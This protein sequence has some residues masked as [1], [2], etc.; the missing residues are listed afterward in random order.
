MKKFAIALMLVLVGLS[1]RGTPSSASTAGRAPV[2]PAKGSLSSYDPQVDKLLAQMTLDEKIG[3]MTQAE[4]SALKDVNDI[5]KYFLGSLL[6]GGDSDPKAGNSVQAWTDI[7]DE[8]QKHALKTRLAIPILFGIDAVHGHNNVLG[9]TIFPH[10]IGLGCTRDAKLIEQAARITAEEVRATGINWVFAPCVAVPRDERWGRTYEGFGETAELARTLGEA[11]VRGFQGADLSNPLSVVACAKHYVGDGG[12]TF[13]TGRPTEDGGHFPLDQGDT[14]L[15]EAELRDIHMQGYVAAIKAGVGTIMPSYSSWN[16]VK[17][18]ASHRLLTEILKDELGFEGFLISD[19]N[20]LDDL[21]GDRKTQIATSINAGMD[22]VMVPTRYVEFYTTLRD[23][24][25]DGQ[26]PMSRIDDA[27]RRI[28]R[29][30]F[31]TGLMDKSRSPL[32]DRSLH[33]TF[34]SPAHRAVARQCVRESLVLLK[35]DKQTLP[36]RKT[37]ARIHVA[38]KSADDIGNQCGGWTIDWQGRS[39]DV[40]TGGTTIFKAI[41][42]AVAKTTKVTFSKDGS[43]AA[44]ADVGIVVIGETPYAEMRGDRTNLALAPEDVAAVENLK[45]AGIPVVVV[46]VSGRPMMIDGV[47]DRADAFIAAWLPGTEGAGVAD[48]LFG[49]YNPTGK[50]SCSWPRSMAQIPI[51]WGDKNYDPLFKYGYGLSYRK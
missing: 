23:L 51:N 46:L 33:K 30:K 7:Y 25:K 15:S 50:L 45:K 11:A 44:G 38:G 32:A 18:S 34:G 14:R 22:M 8:Y 16:S 43:G 4:Q 2:A 42:G 48:V 20:A 21:P 1:F 5:Q 40:M 49:D 28:L 26:V 27:V 24:V 19:Y 37:L 13:G 12:T 31:A 39:G 17:C 3:Q 9:A 29:V 35:N 6:S 47:L 41:Q 10:N 36:L